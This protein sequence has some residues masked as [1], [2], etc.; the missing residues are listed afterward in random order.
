MLSF[1]LFLE[2]KLEYYLK[3]LRFDLQ[4]S[5]LC[6]SKCGTR[7]GW[8]GTDPAWSYYDDDGDDDDDDD[9]DDDGDDDDDDEDDN[10]V[11]GGY[12]DD[13]GDGD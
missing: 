8:G 9:D 6:R 13:D 7:W 3:T 1:S 10:D 5:S 4:E 11:D 2:Q 12:D